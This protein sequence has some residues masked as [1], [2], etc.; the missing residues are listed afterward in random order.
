MI[1]VLQCMHLLF[2]M[3]KEKWKIMWSHVALAI[4]AALTLYNPGTLPTVNILLSIILLKKE[5]MRRISFIIVCAFAVEL[6]VYLSSFSLGIL[7]DGTKIYTK[8]MTHDL[9]F[10][11]SNTPGLYF[12]MLTLCV[13]MFFRLTQRVKFPLLL[14]LLPNYLIYSLTLGR[15]AFYSVCLFFFLMYYFS[16]QR[17]YKIERKVAA[18]LPFLIF[19]VVF[20]LLHIYRMIPIVNVIF[21]GRFRINANTLDDM[22]V[23]Q[24]FT[25]Y[26]VPE[27]PMDC[28]YLGILFNGG[29]I[30]V[31][32]ILSCCCKGIA[33]MSAKTARIFLP[34]VIAMLA[35]GFTEGT[36]SLFR[37]ATVLF[38]KIL[39]DHLDFSYMSAKYLQ[40]RGE[41]A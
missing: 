21:T 30:S 11:N 17:E 36:F 12:M 18:W 37:L 41:I 34:Y 14:F 4:L 7:Q 9:G 31:F 20:L 25:G 33:T 16:F 15:T 2:L 10:R 26:A 40:P 13:S 3:Q 38:Y 35:S 24:Y 27:G 23:A 5:R 29:I 8:G 28:A 32:I 6:L 19:S 1:T 22:G 39:A